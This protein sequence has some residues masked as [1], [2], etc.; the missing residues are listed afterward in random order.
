MPPSPALLHP[1]RAD[2]AGSGS[3]VSPTACARPLAPDRGRDGALARVLLH[4]RSTRRR[5]PRRR[6]NAR[7]GSRAVPRRT[8]RDFV[9]QGL[10]PLPAFGSWLRRGASEAS[11]RAAEF[12]RQPRPGGAPVA[13]HGGLGDAEQLGSRPRPAREEA[14]L[15]HLRLA[16]WRRAR[17]SSAA[18]S[19]SK[20]SAHA[21]PSPSDSSKLTHHRVA[22]PRLRAWRRRAASI[23]T[24]RMARAAMRL[25]WTARSAPRPARATADPRS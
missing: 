9:E 25:K 7:R 5:G 10:N 18:S 24:W 13:E 8:V 22:A 15:D 1:V 19:P 21:A 17:D 23:S 2:S 14:A 6:R 11:A 3:V 16:R 20:S 12:A 4:R